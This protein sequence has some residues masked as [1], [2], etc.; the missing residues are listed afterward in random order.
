[1]PLSPDMNNFRIDINNIARYTN[2]IGAPITIEAYKMNNRSFSPT[3]PFAEHG[4]PQHHRV[5][6]IIKITY[7]VKNV[8]KNKW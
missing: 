7:N 3:E 8:T 6:E 5:I 4:T 2:E 1:M